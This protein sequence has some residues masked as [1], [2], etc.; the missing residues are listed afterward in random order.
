MTIIARQIAFAPEGAP[1]AAAPAQSPPASLVDAAA[2]AAAAAPVTPAPAAAPAAAASATYYPEGLPEGLRGAN[3]RETIDRLYAEI[4]GRPKAPEKPDGYQLTVP[5]TLE[6]VLDP[7]ND[8]VL[9]IYRDVAHKL[10]L[11]QSQ[12]EGTVLNLYEKMAESGLLQKPIDITEQFVELS[13]RRGDRAAQVQSGQRVVLETVSQIDAL[14]TRQQISKEVA[15]TLREDVMGSAKSV[16]AVRAILSLL[17]SERGPGSGGN[18]DT[19]VKSRADVERMMMDPR[20]DRLG[21]A[22]DAAYAEQV[23]R[24]WNALPLSALRS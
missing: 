4:T 21:N 5:K 14:V 18:S 19:G 1:A 20:Y 24:A 2:A 22:F 10:G 7:A 9:P 12:F 23:D 16:A 8:K 3:E 13:D 6:G 11:T 17:P 15:A